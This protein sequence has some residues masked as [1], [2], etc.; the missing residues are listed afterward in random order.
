MLNIDRDLGRFKDIVK[1]RC[2]ARFPH[3]DEVGGATSLEVSQVLDAFVDVHRDVFARVNSD[4]H[5]TRKQVVVNGVDEL[6]HRSGELASQT[7]VAG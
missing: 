3:D 1:G 6:P 2:V 7:P 5:F 4:V